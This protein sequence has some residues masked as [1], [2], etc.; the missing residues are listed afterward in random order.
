[1]TS[2]PFLEQLAAKLLQG[3][4]QYFDNLTIVLPNKRARVFLIEAFKNQ[5]DKNV[6]APNIISIED[7]IQDVAGIR[8]IDSIEVLFEFYEVYA[9]VVP[10]EKLESFEQFA[11]WAKIILQDFNEIDRYLLNPDHVLS[12]LKD[13]EDIKHWSVDADKRTKLID[14]YLKFYNLLIEY[15]R[16]L[17]SHL[18]DKKV[19][20][21]GLIYREA[22]ANI[23]DFRASLD[24]ECNFVFA[25]FNALNAAEEVIIQN[26]IE[27]DKAQIFW[28]SDQAFLKDR[29]HDAGLFLR[30]FKESWKYYKSNSF[31]WTFDDFSKEKNIKIIGTSKSI[32]QAKIVGSI[33]EAI[34]AEG[35]TTL[36]KVAVVLGD[37]NLLLPVLHSLPAQVDRLNITMGYS[38]KNNPVQI[39]ISKLFKMHS[40]ALARNP[41]SYVFYYKDVVDVLTHPLISQNAEG[42]NLVK[43]IRKNNFTFIAHQTLISIQGQ[44]NPLFQLLF[45]KWDSGAE[46][47]L[48]HLSAILLSLKDTLSTDSNQERLTKAFIYSIYKVL[49][50][51]SNYFGGHQSSK[52]IE[53]LTSIYKQVIDLAEVSFEGEPLEGLQLM[54]VLETRVLDF[55]TVIITS[56]NEGKFPAGKSQNSFIPYDVKKELGLP[57][58]KEKD[59]IY[60][61]HFYHL[62]QRAKNI[63]LLY[64]TES[65]GLDGGEKSRFITQLQVEKKPLH[66]LTNE[67][68]T[69][70]VPEVASKDFI[71]EKT[72]SVMTRLAEIAA[73]GF[74]PSALTSYIR[75]PMQ[76]YFQKIL[77]IS[78][79]EDVEENIALNTLGTIIHETLAALYMPLINKVQTEADIELCISKIDDEVAAQ[80][81]LIYK[82]GEIK[83][84]RNLLAFEV[85][86]RHILNFLKL[87]LKAVKDGDSIEI[88]F[89]EKRFERVLESDLLPYPVIIGGSVDRIELRNNV[90]RIIDYKTGKVLGPNLSLKN[91]EN[92]VLDIKN[93]KIIQVLAYALTFEPLLQGKMMEAGVISFKNMK[94]GFLP[95]KIKEGKTETQLITSQILEN[96]QE[97]LIVLL[98]EILDK[99]IPFQ[100]KEVTFF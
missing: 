75:N 97:Q 21:Q 77:S 76:F 83:K 71:I 81:L 90:I 88:L 95:F 26:F 66:N 3:D 41:K 93:D 19:G 18:K 5:I 23:N 47:V 37:E 24:P 44:A 42:E 32:G 79:I 82:K 22:V 8:A 55:D 38:G 73:K 99:K 15:Y 20:Y 39:L 62:L 13:I 9:K 69:P 64:N 12:Y 16:G 94:S 84:G 28:D 33:L 85:A 59:A 43:D 63:Y 45:A 40:N 50:K 56:V 91:W 58:F 11:N 6:F 87:E 35:V 70:F 72:D 1:M 7:F 34:T 51:I 2:T 92:L 30:R 53:T 80:F 4:T 86:K 29:Q 25:G 14:K 54:G 60:T 100:E 67:I 48:D 31:D 61:Y 49:N 98:L 65:E 27:N 68:F 89:L 57:T 78:D 36:N 96:Y 10:V 17:Y 46:A 52:T 74:S